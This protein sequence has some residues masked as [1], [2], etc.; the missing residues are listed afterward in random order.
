MTPRF[1]IPRI[2]KGDEDWAE[3]YWYFVDIVDELMLNRGTL[4]DRPIEGEYDGEPYLAKDT[5]VLYIWREVD[6]WSATGVTAGTLLEEVDG[7]LNVL[8]S[9]ISHDAIDQATVNPNDHHTE[10]SAGSGIT[11]EGTNQFGLENVSNG[12]VTLS[13]GVATVDT[14][15]STNQANEY[16]VW[17]NPGN[18]ADIA[19][20]L[21]AG[22]T[23]YI[24][25]FE[26][27]TTSVGNPDCRWRLMRFTS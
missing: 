8:E 5:G 19:V 22:A 13:G 3:D 10:P 18:Q 21:E 27:N 6:G 26:E 24:I 1:N 7:T 12:T 25:H 23:N 9:E 14:G 15:H 16:D 11:D 17:I 4:A 2:S 20:S